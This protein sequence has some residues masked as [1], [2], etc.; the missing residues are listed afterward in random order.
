M[1]FSAKPDKIEVKH[2]SDGF[3]DTILDR[4]GLMVSFRSVSDSESKDDIIGALR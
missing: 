2:F 3:V 4:H 1:L